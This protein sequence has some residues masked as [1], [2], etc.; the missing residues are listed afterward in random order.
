[1]RNSSK[2]ESG[3]LSHLFFRD[4]PNQRA[5]SFVENSRSN[6][7]GLRRFYLA[8]DFNSTRDFDNLIPILESLQRLRF[9]VEMIQNIIDIGRT[10]CSLC[11]LK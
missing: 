6:N 1:M 2:L 11:V 9:E 8:R 5:F 4:L 3:N 10:L 7:Y